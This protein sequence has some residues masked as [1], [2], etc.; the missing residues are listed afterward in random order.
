MICEVCAS[1]ADLISNV[2]HPEVPMIVMLAED[3]HSK[4]KG[5][6]WCDCQHQLTRKSQPTVRV[7][8]VPEYRV[9]SEE[10]LDE[11]VALGVKVRKFLDGE[12]DRMILDNRVDQLKLDGGI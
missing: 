4:C 12:R 8:T 11:A 1:A 5:G 2:A 3:L 10:V 7:L 6:S 9:I